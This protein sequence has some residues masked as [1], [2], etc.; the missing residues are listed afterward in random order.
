MLPDKDYAQI[1]IKADLKVNT[2]EE[3]KQIIEQLGFHIVE[4]KSLGSQCFLLKVDTKD[5]RE[6]VLMLGQKGFSQI[7]GYNASS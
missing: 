1:M 2:L 7:E 4:T 5:I 3:A 6:V